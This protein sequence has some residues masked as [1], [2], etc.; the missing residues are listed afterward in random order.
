MPLWAASDRRRVGW[1]LGY[2]RKGVIHSDYR[3]RAGLPAGGPREM[4]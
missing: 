3:D 2:L 1:A 4:A